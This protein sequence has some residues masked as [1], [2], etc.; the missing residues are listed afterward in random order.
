ML[1]GTHDGNLI[2]NQEIV[3]KEAVNVNRQEWISTSFKNYQNET[4]EPTKIKF[5]VT[6]QTYGTFEAETTTE[7]TTNIQIAHRESGAIVG[8]FEIQNNLLVCTIISGTT[9]LIEEAGFVEIIE[10][11]TA[12]RTYNEFK[13]KD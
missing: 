5:K 4:I 8:T 6:T 7:Q 2:T 13:F 11:T 9:Q 3:G 10:L 1:K 12:E